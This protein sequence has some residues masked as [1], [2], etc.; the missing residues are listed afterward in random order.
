MTL[1]QKIKSMGTEQLADFLNDVTRECSASDC[2]ACPLNNG[3]WICDRQS[4]L[5]RL[6]EEE[7]A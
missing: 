5:E 1:E 4:I 7:K 6:R 3:Y 2:K